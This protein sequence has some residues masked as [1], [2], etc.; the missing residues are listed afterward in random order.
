M[1]SCHFK[2]NFLCEIA[3]SCKKINIKTKTNFSFW[4]K[5][6]KKLIKNY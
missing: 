3:I 1:L 5:G 6:K 4:I 2:N